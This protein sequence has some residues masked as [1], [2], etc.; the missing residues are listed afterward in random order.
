[1]Q[2]LTL[3]CRQLDQWDFVNQPPVRLPGTRSKKSLS[4][5]EATALKSAIGLGSTLGLGNIF[6]T[7]EEVVNIAS[8]PSVATSVL[9]PSKGILTSPSLAIKF[10][11]SSEVTGSIAAAGSLSAVIGVTGS[12]GIY[13]STTRE[14]GI[15]S[16]IGGSLT[17]NSPGAAAGGEVTLIIGTPSDFAGPYFGV[18]VGVG[19]GVAAA[20]TLLFSPTFPSTPGAPLVLT[21]MGAA[22]NVSAVTPTKFPVNISIQ[23]TNTRISGVK[24]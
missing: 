22:F 4:T 5:T 19:T 2:Q 24:F 11:S 7:A 14:I 8:S 6:K 3:D 20:V 23:V 16:T 10:T 13:A 1:M 15:F 12:F 17:L 18:S 21:Y 9:K